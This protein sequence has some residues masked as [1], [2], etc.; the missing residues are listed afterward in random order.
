MA[1][2]KT[3]LTKASAVKFIDSIKDAQRKA[4]AKKVFALIKQVTGEKPELWSNGM[5]G[6]GRYHY[7]SERS[8]RGGDWPIVGF[9]PRKAALTVYVMQGAKPYATLLKKMGPHKISGG[10]CIYITDLS[11]IDLPILKKIIAGSVA[12]MKKKYK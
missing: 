8:G 12:Y 4:D 1:E 11:K 7:K 9:S 6:F 5:I 10:S 2:L 3:K